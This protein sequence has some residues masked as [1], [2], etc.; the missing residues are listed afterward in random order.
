MLLLSELDSEH[1]SGNE[2]GITLVS[3]LPV[4]GQKPTLLS[5]EAMSVAGLSIPDIELIPTGQ[6]AFTVLIM[7]QLD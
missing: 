3:Q 6:L 1:S 7:L 4:L 5:I 2:N